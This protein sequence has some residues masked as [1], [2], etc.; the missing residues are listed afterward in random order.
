MFRHGDD[1]TS[2]YL[3]RGGARLGCCLHAPEPDQLL[4]LPSGKPSHFF[5]D[6][7][8][9]RFRPATNAEAQSAAP[10]MPAGIC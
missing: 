10:F 8:L 4:L 5:V 3:H 6:A 9:L 2:W 1:S 7:R